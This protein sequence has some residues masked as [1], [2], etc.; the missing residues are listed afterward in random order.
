MWS[1]SK[2]RRGE[3]H[4]QSQSGK[5]AD[6]PQH[7][8]TKEGAA[9]GGFPLPQVQTAQMGDCPEY[10]G[11]NKFHLA[12]VS[13]TSRSSPPIGPRKAQGQI[14]A[15]S[16]RCP[17]KGDSV[18]RQEHAPRLCKAVGHVPIPS[19]LAVIPAPG[20]E[21]LSGV[22][23][24]TGA[25]VQS[26]QHTGGG[27]LQSV[28]PCDMCVGKNASPPTSVR[29]SPWGPEGRIL[30]AGTGPCLF[31][32]AV[33]SIWRLREMF[34]VPSCI[35]PIHSRLFPVPWATQEMASSAT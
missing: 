12:W 22:L 5:P 25:G 18:L 33:Y 1:G 24:A 20:G 11:S 8:G 15:A 13:S 9:S 10:G 7:R 6:R 17:H 30:L 27:T 32:L 29:A 16:L 28:F 2:S 4:D 21:H 23:P 19:H 31:R 35:S 14:Y 34:M 3:K 26:S